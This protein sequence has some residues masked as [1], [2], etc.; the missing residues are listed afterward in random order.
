MLIRIGSLWY[1]LHVDES[2]L[3]ES[4]D[5]KDDLVLESIVQ[6]NVE[7]LDDD[8]EC[9]VNDYDINLDNNASDVMPHM[10][11]EEPI[12][13]AKSNKRKKG[14]IKTKLQL[15]KEE[16]KTANTTQSIGDGKPR[17]KGPLPRIKCRIC[18]RIILKYNFESHLQKMHVPNVIVKKERIKCEIC[19]KELASAGNLKIHQSIH[20]GIKRFGRRS[21]HCGVVSF[22]IISHIIFSFTSLQLLWYQLSS[23]V[24]PDRASEWTHG[25]QTIP[26]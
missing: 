2:M 25:E 23:T 5:H 21:F 17:R 6:I 11:N 10:S 4:D 9:N 3:N 24:S 1:E 19:G 22:Y 26:V 12:E 15:K 8:L 14:A 16:K 7:K 18:D 20:T 13:M